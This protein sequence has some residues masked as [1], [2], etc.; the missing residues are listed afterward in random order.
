MLG[1]LVVGGIS[2]V[3]LTPWTIE[4]EVGTGPKVVSPSGSVVSFQVWKRQAAPGK[5]IQACSGPK[6]EGLWDETI[7]SYVTACIPGLRVLASCGQHSTPTLCCHNTRKHLTSNSAFTSAAL[8]R[9]S[10]ASWA[11][12]HDTQMFSNI[13]SLGRMQPGCN[14]PCSCGVF[15]RLKSVLS[16]KNI[17]LILDLCLST[18]IHP[19]FFHRLSWSGSQRLQLFVFRRH[20]EFSSQC[21]GAVSL[22]QGAHPNPRG[23]IL[24]PCGGN[25]LWL[26]ESTIAFVWPLLVYC[27]ASSKLCGNSNLTAEELWKTAQYQV[28]CASD[29]AMN[30]WWIIALQRA[31]KNDAGRKTSSLCHNS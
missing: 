18:V 10:E 15:A 29:C 22:F 28:W 27:N 31:I 1:S 16:H 26:L 14:W 20:P 2:V 13:V 23:W 30:S 3:I 19:S 9:W 25:S 5:E 7:T 8:I 4:V 17:H 11:F 21:E 12:L 6:N 24:T